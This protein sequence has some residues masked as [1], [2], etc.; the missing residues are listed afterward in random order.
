MR[1]MTGCVTVIWAAEHGV[2]AIYA[3]KAWISDYNTI[4]DYNGFLTDNGRCILKMVNFILNNADIMLIL[5]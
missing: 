4:S 1:K 5:C 2:K 3:E